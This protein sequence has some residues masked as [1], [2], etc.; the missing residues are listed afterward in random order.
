M[1]LKKNCKYAIVVP[2]SMGVRITPANR[3]PVHISDTFRMQATSAETNVISIAAALGEKTKVLTTF[4]EGSPIAQF[5]KNDL[6]RR[7]IDYEG[8]EVPQGGPW[9]YRHQFNIADS[10]FAR[11]DAR[12]I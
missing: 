7:G 6:S 1:E 9:G 8:K 12:S 11:S 5:I 2:S 3:Q 4:V 10:G